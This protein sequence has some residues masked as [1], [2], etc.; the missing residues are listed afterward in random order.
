MTRDT[1]FMIFLIVLLGCNSDVNEVQFS[2]NELI[3]F[4]KITADFKAPEFKWGYLNKEGSLA[5]ADKYDDLREFNEGK[6]AFNMNGLWG[7]LNKDGSI[8]LPARYKTVEEYSEERAVVQDL[9]NKY[10]LI[11][12]NGVIISDSIPYEKINKY[13]NGRA[14]IKD[15]QRYGYIDRQ[16]ELAIAMDYEYATDFIDGLAIVTKNRKQGMI[17]INGS[18]MIPIKYDKLWP[19]KSG[20]IRYRNNN[21]FGYIDFKSKNEVFSTFSSATDF[22]D[23][24]AV[25]NNGNNYLLIDK[26]GRTIHL[27]YTLVDTGGEGKWIYALN[28]SYGFLDNDG[29]VLCPPNFDLVMRY[30][31]ERAGFALNDVWGYLDEDGKIVIP[32]KYPLVWDFIDGYARMIGGTGFGF[33]N[34]NGDDILPSAYM[35][36]RDFSEGLARIQVYR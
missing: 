32:P 13:L 9:N 22:Q 31:E 19:V 5:I 10:H 6:A 4:E 1:L 24:H 14:L 28:A 23:A 36:V 12:N 27:P 25:V 26:T 29:V 34:K 18:F 20:M 16:G 33:I 30:R 7:Y 17:D 8:F 11:D 15:S 3:E 21:K 35:E 2:G